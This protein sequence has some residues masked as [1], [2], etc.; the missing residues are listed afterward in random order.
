LR[1]SREGVRRELCV[2]CV[3]PQVQSW[4]A[5][6]ARVSAQNPVNSNRLGRKNRL[7]LLLRLDLLPKI[8]PWT[9]RT[10][11]ESWSP[12]ER[13]DIHGAAQRTRAR[14]RLVRERRRTNATICGTRRTMVTDDKSA[15]HP[16]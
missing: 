10:R 9:W 14:S 1:S 7:L 5:T 13:E 12:P 11:R 3:E 4:E 6:I 16:R 2:N 15:L 8:K